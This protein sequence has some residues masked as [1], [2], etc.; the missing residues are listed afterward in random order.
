MTCEYS[1]V[2]TTKCS[3]VSTSDH[4]KFWG[5]LAAMYSIDSSGDGFTFSI[6][7]HW[8]NCET[9]SHLLGQHYD[10]KPMNCPEKEYSNCRDNEELNYVSSIYSRK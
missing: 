10:Y 4:I 5:F 7:E 1:K 9:D 8:P 6:L 3:L 2:T